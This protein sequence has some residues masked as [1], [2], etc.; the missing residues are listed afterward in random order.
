M[1]RPLRIQFEDAIYHLCGRGND[2]RQIF[3]SD[4]D[5]IY[6]LQLLEKIGPVV[7]TDASGNAKTNNYQV[8]VS[9]G[10]NRTLSYDLTGN[11]INDSTK[12][13]EWD[14]AN[15]LIAI[16]YTNTTNR[17]EF[18]YDGLSRRVKILEKTGNTINSTKRF[19]WDGMVIA[20]ERNNTNKVTRKH[21]LQGVQFL[22]YNPNTSTPYFYMRDHLGSIREMTD[23]TGLIKARYDYDPWGNRIKLGGGQDADFGFSGH[24]YHPPSNLHLALYRAYDS[25]IGRWISRD[26]IA[27]KGGLNFYGY[28]LNNPLNLIDP[29]GLDAI[30]TLQGV[31]LGNSVNAS[32]FGGGRERGHMPSAYG[33]YQ[34]NADNPEA[35]LPFRL[36]QDQRQV[37]VYNPQNNRQTRCEVTDVGPWNTRDPYWRNGARPMAESQYASGTRA[38]NGQVP[39][40]NAGIDLTPGAMNSLGFRGPENTRQGPVL[41]HSPNEAFSGYFPFFGP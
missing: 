14:A 21:Y 24:Y 41:W 12:T 17:T 32:E 4:N 38:Q 19:V 22:S 31:Y 10:A 5:R 33:P 15:R 29:L 26:P 40:N 1:S 11:L 39:S 3:Q 37:D 28:V 6:F 20:E 7:A 30:L 18:T 35:A 2:R 16:N 9:S 25:T 27:E 34:V 36:P 13:F 8:T 23:S